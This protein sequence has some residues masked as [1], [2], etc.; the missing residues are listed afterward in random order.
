[1]VASLVRIS[2][3]AATPTPYTTYSMSV[4]CQQCG[5]PRQT[6][7]PSCPFCKTLYDTPA[8]VG[9]P[10]PPTGELPPDVARA[11][12]AGNMIEAVKL[13]R[14]VFKVGLKEA[15]ETLDRELARRR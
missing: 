5:A 6:S 10:P 14:Q 7:A 3:N 2:L 4:L 12:A 15:K 13:Y 9:A 1:M 11:L 8:P